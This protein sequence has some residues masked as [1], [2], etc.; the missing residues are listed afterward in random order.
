MFPVKLGK[1]PTLAGGLCAFLVELG[2][3]EQM[4]GA[5]LT[6]GDQHYAFA[7][8]GLDFELVASFTSALF[9]HR[10]WVYA[11]YIAPPWSALL[12]LLRSDSLV[13]ASS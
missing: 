2:K 5:N 1:M 11:C 3:I 4:H 9:L 7:Q 10:N 12:T 13:R 8:S 6:T